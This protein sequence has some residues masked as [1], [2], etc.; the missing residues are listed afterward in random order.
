MAQGI[1]QS[2]SKVFQIGVKG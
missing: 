1:Q 2:A